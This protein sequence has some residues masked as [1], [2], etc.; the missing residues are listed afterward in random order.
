MST[1][2]QLILYINKIDINTVDITFLMDFNDALVKVQINI[3][4]N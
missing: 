1:Q 3:N 2:S 4:Q